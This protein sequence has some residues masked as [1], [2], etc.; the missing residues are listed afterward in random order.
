MEVGTAR[1]TIPSFQSFAGRFTIATYD[2]RCSSGSSGDK[3]AVV[4]IGQ[5][6]RDV[7]AIIKALGFDKAYIFGSS[8][9]GVI[10]L[11]IAA[12]LPEI[13]TAVIAHEP[14]TMAILD[15]SQM[16]YDFHLA[17]YEKFLVSGPMA[18]MGMFATIFRG[19][20]KDDLAISSLDQD[21]LVANLNNFFPK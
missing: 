11:E 20:S 4:N 7:R 6:T 18:A 5:Q 2:R 12:K 17:T 8:A 15:D 16:L 3:S 10:A 9:G 14:P 21:E 1:V 13:A 19:L